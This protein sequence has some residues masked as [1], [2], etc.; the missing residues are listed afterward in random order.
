MHSLVGLIQ[1][2]TSGYMPTAAHE[3]GNDCKVYFKG[4]RMSVDGSSGI[5]GSQIRDWEIDCINCGKLWAGHY[6]VTLYYSD[7]GAT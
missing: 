5:D 1:I 7:F 6:K 3:G 4:T 2:G